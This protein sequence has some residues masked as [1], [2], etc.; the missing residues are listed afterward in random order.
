MNT[1]KREWTT[2]TVQ[3]LEGE[4]ARGDE[5]MNDAAEGMIGGDEFGPS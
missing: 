5:K 2:P 1:E 3:E 4:L